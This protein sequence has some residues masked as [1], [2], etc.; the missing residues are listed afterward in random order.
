MQGLV[1]AK[2]IAID[3]V[4]GVIAAQKGK[5]GAAGACSVRCSAVYRFGIALS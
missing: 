2:L 1:Y 4:V 5:E 3:K